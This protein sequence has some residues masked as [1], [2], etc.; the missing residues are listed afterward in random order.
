[1]VD[2]PSSRT[3]NEYMQTFPNDTRE[4]LE[5]VRRTILEALPGAEE[6]ISYGIP[7]VRLNDRYVIYFSGWKDHIALYPRPHSDE[8]LQKA[9]EPYASGKGTIRFELDQPIPYD[10]VAKVAQTLASERHGKY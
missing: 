3:V 4:L 5:K 8:A 10:L 9:L 2:K 6:K 7:G 1:M